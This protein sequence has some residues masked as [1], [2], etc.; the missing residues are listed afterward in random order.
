[1]KARIYLTYVFLLLLLSCQG[2]LES[3]PSSGSTLYYNSFENSSDLI[4]W[5]GISSTSLQNDA[6][7]FGGKKSI[8]ISGGCIVPHASYT[9]N[10]PGRDIKITMECFGKN[11]SNGGTIELILGTERLNQQYILI[12]DSKWKFYQLDAEIY[13]PADSTLTIWFISGGDQ[14]SSMLID[15]L[16]L[17]E[18]D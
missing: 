9:F 15:C 11:L 16:R 3:V 14:P 2:V 4:G 1:M 8:Y 18:V 5:F 6:P 12:E 10:S 17:V 13:W 7:L